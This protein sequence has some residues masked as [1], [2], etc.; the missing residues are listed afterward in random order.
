MIKFGWYDMLRLLKKS[1]KIPKRYSE[2]VN[3]KGHSTM[4]TRKSIIGEK[5][6]HK[7]THRKQKI[8]QHERQ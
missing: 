5:M 2:A 8:E 3:R 7:N 1:L 4:A 6:I